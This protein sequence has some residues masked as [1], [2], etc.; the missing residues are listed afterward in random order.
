MVK[1]RGRC[2]LLKIGKISET[3]LVVPNITVKL[4][5]PAKVIKLRVLI[6]GILGLITGCHKISKNVFF[7]TN[8]TQKVVD[9][10]GTALSP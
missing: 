6:D 5:D 9:A 2:P 3:V 1:G 10:G 4:I 7:E 8:T